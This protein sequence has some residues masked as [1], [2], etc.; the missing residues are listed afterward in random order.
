MFFFLAS[1]YSFF[2]FSGYLARSRYLSDVVSGRL[3][4]DWTMQ[5]QQTNGLF[6]IRSLLVGMGASAIFGTVSILGLLL[7][8]RKA[9]SITPAHIFALWSLGFLLFL[10]MTY[11]KF[12]RYSA[13]LIPILALFAAKFLWDMS[14]FRSGKIL[15]SLAIL[16]QIVWA[17]MC[18]HVYLT[19][20]P[21]RAAAT[22]IAQHIPQK[23]TI[24]R[25]E[26]NSIIHFDTPPLIDKQY[27]LP[28]FNFYTLPD[29]QEKMDR[30]TNVLA[31]SDYIVL[32]SPKIKNTILRQK[33]QYPLT[34]TYYEQLEMEKL[35]FHQVAQ[36]KSLPQL[37]PFAI[38]DQAAEETWYAFDHP[39]VTIYK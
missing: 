6:W 24:L 18:F 15:L 13:P 37:G 29:T 1:P 25:E 20:H 32:E 19:P 10:S 17:V 14:K 21:A 5:F 33:N 16:A 26:W 12:I 36:F 34:S 3:L 2:D 9:K 22:W 35:G 7:N 11:L 31:T 4:M 39:T 8:W 23:S 38:D 27:N 28:M 30:L